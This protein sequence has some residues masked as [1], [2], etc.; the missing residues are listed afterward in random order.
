M[1]Q[2]LRWALSAH[3]LRLCSA[4]DRPQNRRLE[5]ALLVP[6]ALPRS[7]QRDRPRCPRVR[8]ESERRPE[9]Q[10]EL[11]GVGS[12]AH[13][14]ADVGEQSALVRGHPSGFQKFSEQGTIGVRGSAQTK[15]NSESTPSEPPRRYHQLCSSARKLLMFVLLD[16]APRAA[17]VARRARVRQCADL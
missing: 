12:R 2:L 8:I 17:G 13:R 5:R 10:R 6:S 9:R 15:L 4:S 11:A 1:H 14:G 16:K 7:T 3:M